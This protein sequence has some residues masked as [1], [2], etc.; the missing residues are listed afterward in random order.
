MFEAPADSELLSVVEDILYGTD[1]SD[2]RLPTPAELVEF[3]EAA[4]IL[5]IT[6]HPDGSY[7]ATAPDNRLDILE[8]LDNGRFRINSPSLLMFNPDR[9]VV[10]SY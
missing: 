7:T 4:S 8:V 2:P 6:V 9:F 3:F 10:H 1:S 5:R